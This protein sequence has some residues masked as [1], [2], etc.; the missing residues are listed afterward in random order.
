MENR[1]LINDNMSNRKEN[2]P[3]SPSLPDRPALT[4]AVSSEYFSGCQPQ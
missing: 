1:H 4:Q 3:H 2:R